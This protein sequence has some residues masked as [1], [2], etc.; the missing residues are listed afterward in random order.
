MRGST[1][2]PLQDNR[3]ESEN[4]KADGRRCMADTLLFRRESA[5]EYFKELVDGAL[6]H[7]RIAAGELTAFYVVQMLAGFLQRPATSDEA[8]LGMRLAQ[9]LGAGG[10]QQRA[11]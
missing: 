11:S 1:H 5:I 8:P 4:R 3:R 7:Q 9:A 10:L 6:A 2:R